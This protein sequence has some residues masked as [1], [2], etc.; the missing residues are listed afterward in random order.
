MAISTIQSS[1]K[2]LP[3]FAVYL[4]A[5]LGVGL[6]VY[7]GGNLI[8]SISNLTGKAA[9]SVN[10]TY[11]EAQVL[12]DGKLVGDTPY[13]SKNVKPGNNKITLTQ[14]TRQYETNIKV[15]SNSVVGIF[16]DLGISEIFSSG[17]SFWL[18]KDS[19]GTTLRIISEP[20]GAKVYVD[21]TE[22]GQTPFSSD[23]LSEGDYDIRIEFPGFESQKARIKIQNGYTSNIQAKLFPMPV[24]SRVK[25][26][27]DSENLY[28]MSSD[29]TQ[30]TTDPMTWVKAVVYWNTTRGVNLEGIGINKDLVFGYFVD[31]KGN[32]YDKNG[33]LVQN[34]EDFVSLQDSGDT[35]AYLGKISDGDGLTE[36]AKEAYLQFNNASVGGNNKKVEILP[37]GLGWLRVRDIA[38]TGDEVATVDVGSIYTVLEE[39]NGWTKIKVDDTTSG[40]VSNAYIKII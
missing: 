37:T 30:V 39:S 5:I 36:A 14:G 11:G 19:S 21:S 2:N 17:Q 29:N 8:K 10:T 25:M 15:I 9:L 6:L 1:K 34:S 40:W 26:F 23:N 20:A 27:E 16:R 18:D 32:V 24:P 33:D 31:Y 28:N 13:N 35:G 4:A 38:Q 3:Q 22:I 12:I 7:F